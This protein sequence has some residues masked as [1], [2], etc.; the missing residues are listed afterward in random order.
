MHTQPST[1]I[2]IMGLPASGKTI[3]SEKLAD[4]TNVPLLAKDGVKELL[5]DNLGWSDRA[6]SEKLGNATYRLMDYFIEQQLKAGNS[7]IV[8]STFHPKYDNPKMQNWQNLYG[9]QCIQILCHADGDVLLERFRQRAESHDR[10]P[11]QDKPEDMPGFEAKMLKGR[12]EVLDLKSTIIE[13]DTTDFSKV[14]E[15]AIFRQIA[16]LLL[17]QSQ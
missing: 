7:L 15:G 9:F 11:G 8:E 12:D 3:L 5:F 16:G 14:D 4:Y 6:W 2:L 1:L 17:T 13:V 10:H